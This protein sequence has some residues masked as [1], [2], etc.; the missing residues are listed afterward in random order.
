M[1]IRFPRTF[2]AILI[3][4]FATFPGQAQTVNLDYTN[5]D[6]VPVL[7]RLAKDAGKN[8]YLSPE[9]QG[10]VTVKAQ[11]SSPM[12]AMDLILSLQERPYRYKVLKNT[13]VVASPEK[14]GTIPDDL[15]GR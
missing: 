14:L 1:T 13:I 5:A 2:L 6:L 4:L 7:K 15:F 12:E 10:R 8:I 11:K 9:V 3:V